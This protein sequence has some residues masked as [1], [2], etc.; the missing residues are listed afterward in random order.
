MHFYWVAVGNIHAVLLH[1]NAD[2]DHGAMELQLGFS[3][4]VANDLQGGA[5]YR[6]L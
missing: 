2:I 5:P 3:L 1:L 4:D 6:L